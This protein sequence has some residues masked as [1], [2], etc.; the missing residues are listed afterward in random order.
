MKIVIRDFQSIESVELET[1]G[2]TVI[3]GKSNLGKSAFI[4]AIE[5]ALFS[6]LGEAFVREGKKSSYVCLKDL[7]G[8]K[9]LEWEKGQGINVFKI[10]GVELAKVGRSAPDALS[11][12]GFRDVWIGDKERKRGE[13]IR[14][15]IADQFEPLFL[16]QKPGSFVSEVLSAATRINVL[17]VAD[18]AC[19]LDLKAN[20]SLVTVRRTDLEEAKKKV[21]LLAPVQLLTERLSILKAQLKEVAAG[22]E[23]IQKL[24]SLIAQKKLYVTTIVAF[25]ETEKAQKQRMDDIAGNLHHYNDV[26]NRVIALSQ[27]AIQVKLSVPEIPKFQPLEFPVRKGEQITEKI[28]HLT[29]C[30]E[31][32]KHRVPFMIPPLMKYDVVLEKLEQNRNISLVLQDHIVAGNRWFHQMQMQQMA[33][34]SLKTEIE[35][36]EAE[37]SEL[38]QQLQVCPVCDQP[39]VDEPE[40]QKMDVLNQ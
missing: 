39:L 28:L 11:L 17:N 7:P 14:P 3:V 33:V 34:K 37:F 13:F 31:V 23:R 4:R 21:E 16:L 20:R 38:K 9:S 1:E 29:S 24:S 26:R 36:T 19:S 25:I 6:R 22:K 10:D 8:F 18:R 27:L 40:I 2:F 30:V 35:T 15:Q 5:S 12:A 32:L